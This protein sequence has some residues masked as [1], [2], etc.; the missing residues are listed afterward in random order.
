M[1]TVHIA[2]A[3][4]LAALAAGCS[5]VQGVEPKPARPVKAQPVAAAPAAASVRYSASIEPFEQVTLAF[6]SSGYVDEI[7]RRPGADGRSRVA[8][9]GDL[10]T[11]GAVLARVRDADY[12]QHLEQGRAS[13]TQGEASL[14]KARLDLDRAKTLFAAD[15][16]TKPDLDAAQANFDTAEAR[17]VASRADVEL[18]RNALHDT[19]L[20]T[21]ATGILLERRIEVGTLVGAG[22]VG[23][24]LG[25]VSAVKARFGIP[26]SEIHAIQPGDAIDV[27]VEALNGTVFS[28][29]VT[30]VAPAADPKSRVFDVEVT[31]PNRDGRPRSG[32]IGT[33]TI[34]QSGDPARATLALPLGAIVRS[35]ADPAG[36]AVFVVE[37]RGED[38]VARVRTVS[39]GDVVGNGVAVLGGVNA[40]DRVVTSG[41][42]LLTDG[43]RIRVI[44]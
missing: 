19:A 40:G 37:A 39:L 21:P 11:K 4:T 29:R 24:V 44:P 20:V 17:V 31:I 23:F 13:L 25:D 10:V 22:T 35:P 16:L 6:K 2:G 34:G 8:Q 18:A 28:G 7:L 3:I 12:Q 1:R 43:D 26:D 36:Y 9:A 33:V 38:E 42:T 5:N 41:A 15:S 27:V 14:T 32:M 30:A